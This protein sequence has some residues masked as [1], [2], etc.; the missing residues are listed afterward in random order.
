[1]NTDFHWESSEPYVK[2]SAIQSVFEECACDAL[3]LLDCCAAAGAALNCRKGIIETTTACGFETW[4][5]GPGRHS[6]TNA[7]IK[8][9]ED[10]RDKP[11]FSAAMLHAEIL[12]V[13]K[14]DRPERR[15]RTDANRVENRKTPI[16]IL[17]SNDSRSNS[18][19]LSVR[20]SPDVTAAR[21]ST[22]PNAPWPNTQDTFGFPQLNRDSP[23]GNLMVPHVLLSVALDK[24]QSL[25]VDS[26]VRWISDN[27]ALAKYV[28]VE[29]VFR[30]HS[31]IVIISLPVPIWDMLQDDLA[32]S[33]IA[34]VESR[35]ALISASERANVRIQQLVSSRAKAKLHIE[36]LEL[37]N[38][39]LQQ[40]IERE[41]EQAR[42]QYQALEK[43]FLAEVYTR[44]KAEAM[45]DEL[46][47]C[48][49]RGTKSQPKKP[50][51]S[52]EI[53]NQD[54][55]A[56]RKSPIWAPSPTTKPFQPNRVP[57]PIRPSTSAT[58]ERETSGFRD[59]A[60]DVHSTAASNI[61]ST[62][63]GWSGANDNPHRNVEYGSK[64][65]Y[66]I[67]QPSEPETGSLKLKQ[68]SWTQ[69]AGKGAEKGK[70]KE[71]E[72]P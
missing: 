68:G 59:D 60:S 37:I 34:Y 9:L 66:L 4:S 49:G 71:T 21:R 24:D 13:I 27:P 38:S 14:H 54:L 44:K 65:D 51:E 20:P 1:M 16:Y 32:I 48:D 53:Q 57:V 10:W 61:E 25:D 55:P 8:I 18:I 64:S 15:R 56:R 11:S 6:F 7:L 28:L 67:V 45:L 2:W 40:R 50:V 72:T 5:P 3:F 29:G 70:M 39:K 47:F 31:T 62:D 46:N 35:N 63:S 58:Q 36:E 69:V 41:R 43:G 33:F 42:G 23:S 52:Y 17:T 30:S 19:E 22:L 12:S 26:W